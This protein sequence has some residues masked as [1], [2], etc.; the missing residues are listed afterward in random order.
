MGIKNSE[1]QKLRIN[2]RLIDADK[3]KFYFSKKLL[4]C[5]LLAD[6]HLSF[7]KVLI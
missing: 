6:K 4:K 7:K 3:N 1:T 2:W 5:G